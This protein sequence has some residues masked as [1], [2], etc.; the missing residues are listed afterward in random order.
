MHS[1]LPIFFLLLDGIVAANFTFTKIVSNSI[2]FISENDFF[3]LQ[4][5]KAQRKREKKNEIER[6]SERA[7][8]LR[9]VSSPVRSYRRIEIEHSRGSNSANMY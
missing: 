3:S 1:V 9:E 8:E 4:Y 5:K 6:A 7:C 2:E